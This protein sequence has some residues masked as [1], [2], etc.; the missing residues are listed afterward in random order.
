MWCAYTVIGKT[1]LLRVLAGQ[2][3]PSSGSGW[4]GLMG[5]LR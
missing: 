2:E 4:A 5:V 3:F 1:T